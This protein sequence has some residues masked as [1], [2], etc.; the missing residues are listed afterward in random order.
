MTSGTGGGAALLR[1]RRCRRTVED[2]GAP[3]SSRH[4]DISF[5][6]SILGPLIA[7]APGKG[8]RRG[9]YSQHW[10]ATQ[11]QRSAFAASADS[12]RL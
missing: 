11:V 12:S 5:S 1:W 2:S 9:V 6:S 10:T 7:G 8:L 3:L 4:F